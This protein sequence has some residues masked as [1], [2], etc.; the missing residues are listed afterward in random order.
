MSCTSSLIQGRNNPAD[1]LTRKRFPNCLGPAQHTRYDEPDSA[2]ELV[3]ASS[4]PGAACASVFVLQQGCLAPCTP[5]SRQL[6]A[7]HL[8]LTW[9]AAPWQANWGCL[10]LLRV[11]CGS[12]SPAGTGYSTV[13]FRAATAFTCQARFRRSC[14]TPVTVHCLNARPLGGHFCRD[15]TLA[16]ERCL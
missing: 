14:C 5:I 8:S 4:A 11:L 9:P 10:Q 6:F 15:K 1:F 16:L 13:S 12:P 7:L 2:L 3:T